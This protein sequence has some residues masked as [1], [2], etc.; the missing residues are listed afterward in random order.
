MINIHVHDI[1]DMIDHKCTKFIPNVVPPLLLC[2]PFHIY[3]AIKAMK[4]Q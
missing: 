2:L 1:L 3:V 4:G